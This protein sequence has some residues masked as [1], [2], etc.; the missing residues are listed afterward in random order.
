MVT[1]WIFPCFRFTRRT[2]K[3]IVKFVNEKC[4]VSVDA[5]KPHSFVLHPNPAKLS[6]MADK[7]LKPV[8]ADLLVGNPN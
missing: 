1:L 6:A 2:V 5:N 7:T 4:G 3:A 8:G